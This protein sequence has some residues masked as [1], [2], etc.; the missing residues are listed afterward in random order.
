MLDGHCL[1]Q[2]CRAVHHIYFCLEN[3]DCIYDV[4]QCK[5]LTYLIGDVKWV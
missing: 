5:D 4:W 1:D 2:D 3:V